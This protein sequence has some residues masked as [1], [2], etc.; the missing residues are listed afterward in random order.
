MDLF[1]KFWPI[2]ILA[3]VQTIYA[4][5]DS[6]LFDADYFF[7]RSLQ[8][9]GDSTISQDSVAAILERERSGKKEKRERELSNMSFED[10][11]KAAFK[12]EAPPRAHYF[13][14]RFSAD[15]KNFGNTEVF[16]DSAFTSFTFNSISFSNYLDTVLIDEMRSAINDS[17]GVFNSERLNSLGFEVHLNDRLY[18]LHVD[19]P[20]LHKHLQRMTLSRLTMPSG[21]LIQPAFFSFYSNLRG[22]EYYRCMDNFSDKC[23]RGPVLLNTDGA[24]ALGGFVVE[25]EGRFMEKLHEPVTKKNFKRGNLRLVKDIYPLNSRFSFGDVGGV[26][27][28][29]VYEPMGGIRYEHHEN[30]FNRNISTERHKVNF[31]LQKASRVE[32]HLDG[33]FYRRLLLPAGYHEI[34]GFDG[35]AGANTVQIFIHKDDGSLEEVRYEFE[36]GDG[37]TLYKG[38]RRYSLTAGFMRTQT[39]YDFEYHADEPGLNAE[40]IYGLFHSISAGFVWQFSRQNTVTGFQLMNS[41]ILGHTE[42][43]GL[44]S[45]DS[46]KMGR[47]AELRHS[48]N[49][50][51]LNF[52]L[53]GYM[54]NSTY[55]PYLFQPQHGISTEYAGLTGSSGIS[56]EN[57]SFSLN[58]GAYFNREN[59]MQNPVDYHYGL[60][61]SH[62]IYGLSLYAA[63]GKSISKIR[64]NTTI[65]LNANYG[66]GMKIKNHRISFSA[67]MDSYYNH[68]LQEY[69]KDPYYEENADESETETVEQSDYTLRKR[70]GL[71]WNWSQ[72][73]SNTWGQNYSANVSVQDSLDPSARLNARHYFNRLQTNAS[74]TYYNQ[75]SVFRANAA[76]SFMFADGLWA[77]G[78]PVS[79]G[80]ILADVDKSLKGST[81]L[82]NPSQ[83]KSLSHSGW[84]GAAYK[85]SIAN[86]RPTTINLRLIDMP[87]GAWLNSSKYYV[88]GHY[89]QGY[90]LRLGNEMRVLMQVRLSDEKGNLSNYY[91]SVL[92]IDNEGKATDNDKRI[93]FTSRD[94][95][96]QIGDLVPGEKYRVIFDPSTYIKDIDIKIPKDSEPFLEL[97]DIKV[98]RE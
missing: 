97:P 1:Y 54:Q 55:N 24:I 75:A 11:F 80:F 88:A 39:I 22:S 65:S 2:L 67:G 34:S 14:A 89:K 12:Q 26:S 84:L 77:F 64:T 53:N 20:P 68:A 87:E 35:R 23:D 46:L 4:A 30:L 19:L 92:H 94:G 57:T 5:S 70:A 38:E 50:K 28:L 40:Y 16:Y 74:L 86:Y 95:I 63:Y 33:N 59:E 9:H 69:I 6:T 78:R 60:S 21:V 37:S 58:G 90:A 17:S 48:A 66:F 41:N 91:I 47:R 13:I 61:L 42:F 27:N 15:G 73:G 7:Q 51:K 32:I 83:D 43:F 56:Y 36:L 79:R 25:G 44:V 98:K 81:V 8:R 76:T 3:M 72:G 85:N 31:F 52:S 82:V 71:G 62:Y 96:L 93:T 49:I 18:Q 29:M 10:L 45:K